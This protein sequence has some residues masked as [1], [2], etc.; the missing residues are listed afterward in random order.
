MALGKLE[1]PPL[2]CSEQLNFS[3]DNQRKQNQIGWV[4]N[5]DATLQ[6]LA[7][8]AP[9]NATS[10]EMLRLCMMIYDVVDVSNKV[11]VEAG[12]IRFRT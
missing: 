6:Q 11:N 5:C 2:P 10:N 9:T 7:L 12:K 8:E 3:N 1:R 4:V